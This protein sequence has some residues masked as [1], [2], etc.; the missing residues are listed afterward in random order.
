MW[1]LYVIE[2]PAKE[3]EGCDCAKCR[4]QCSD[5]IVK[6]TLEHV[7]EYDPEAQEKHQAWLI[8]LEPRHYG[9]KIRSI[10]LPSQIGAYND[11]EVRVVNPLFRSVDSEEIGV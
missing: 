11:L 6:Y 7:S 4:S 10:E 3:K 9:S 5:V 2:T 1:K 8:E